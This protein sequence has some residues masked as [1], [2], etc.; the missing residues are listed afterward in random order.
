M[1]CNLFKN[2]ATTKTLIFWLLLDSS[3]GKLKSFEN[4]G[5]IHARLAEILSFEVCNWQ[6]LAI[7]QVT[8]L[9]TNYLLR[10][11]RSCVTSGWSVISCIE[12]YA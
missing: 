12:N 7:R 2:E 1:H 11:S 9:P 10:G 6:K 4:F 8:S 3:M 5:L